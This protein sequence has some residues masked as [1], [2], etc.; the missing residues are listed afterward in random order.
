[1]ADASG[2]RDL[3]IIVPRQQEAFPR[4]L[5]E[6]IHSTLLKASVR[7]AESGRLPFDFSACQP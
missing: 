3:K 1:M 4:Q 5:L 2:I 7:L 6:E